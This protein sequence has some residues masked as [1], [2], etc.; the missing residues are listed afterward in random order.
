M[1]IKIL[2]L[3]YMQI[4][5]FYCILRQDKMQRYSYLRL[6]PFL[7]FNNQHMHTSTLLNTKMSS[8]CTTQFEFNS[9]TIRLNAPSAPSGLFYSYNG[10]CLQFGSY[11]SAA[12]QDMGYTYHSINYSQQ[13][14]TPYLEEFV[15]GRRKNRHELV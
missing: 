2:L 4:K 8:V 13:I 1:Q 14:T 10:C 15:S 12:D 11:Q 5:I 6:E 3:F 7:S 9:S